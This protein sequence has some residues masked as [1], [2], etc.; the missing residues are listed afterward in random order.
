[1]NSWR[2]DTAAWP[3]AR[4][5]HAGRAPAATK[6]V[7][8]EEWSFPDKTGETLLPMAWTACARRQ[9][10][11][12]SARPEKLP[13]LKGKFRAIGAGARTGPVAI[14]PLCKGF[15]LCYRSAEHWGN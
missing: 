7:V 5:G 1:M 2:I 11:G 10:G 9:T 6:S 12:L 15:V 13:R 3:M 4:F 8:F 14:R